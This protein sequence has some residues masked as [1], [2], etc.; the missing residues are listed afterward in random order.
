[1]RARGE[2]RM[3]LCGGFFVPHQ[4]RVLPAEGK[5]KGALC[6]AG[7]CSRDGMEQLCQEFPHQEPS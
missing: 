4:I 7:E 1:M 5:H 2:A 6:G 3:A